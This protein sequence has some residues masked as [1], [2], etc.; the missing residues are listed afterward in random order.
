MDDKALYQAILG[1]GKPWRVKGVDLRL[2]DGEVWIEV[3]VDSTAELRCPSCGQA[4]S[5]YDQS[6]QRQWRHL[7]T[8]QYRT[9]VRGRIPRVRCAEH[10]V[11]QIEVHWAEDRSRF[12]ALFEAFAIRVLRECSL[13]AA[14]ELLGTS[15]EEMAGIQRRAVARGLARRVDEPV[16][17]VGVDETSFQKRHEY[18][19][20]VIDLERDRVLWVGDQRREVTLRK[21][22]EQ[23]SPAQLAS[24]EAIVMDMW[25][26]YIA[27]TRNAVP[28]G[29]SKVVFDRYHVM[30]HVNAAVDEVRKAEQRELRRLGDEDGLKHLKGTRFLWLRG[31]ATRQRRDNRAIHQLR[32]AGLKVGRAWAIKES[33]T[34][35][36]S[37][38]RPSA[39]KAFFTRWY[40]WAT[41]SRLPSMIKAA[42]TLKSYLY[43]ILAFTRHPYTNARTEAVNAKI[44]EIKYRARGYRNRDNFRMAI[45]FHCGG[46]Q[47]DPR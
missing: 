47:M 14:A 9:I 34:Q 3:E 17:V 20:V 7:D 35:L 11:R 36:W 38:K 2:G 41:H 4:A 43:G 6:E 45:L 24:L 16:R 42:K 1:L 19:T 30:W 22:W 31:K 28:N 29:L 44:Q 8:C 26:P 25:D 5:R 33:V 46:L 40:R 39:A 12:T 15:W 32:K 10:G 21:Y 18:I 23:H 13:S 37:Y 27:A